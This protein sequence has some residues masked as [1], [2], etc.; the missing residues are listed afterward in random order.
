M[1]FYT[2]HSLSTLCSEGKLETIDR[3]VRPHISS[4]MADFSLHLIL[5]IDK[6]NILYEAKD[7]H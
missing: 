4:D 6:K 7:I 3:S 2:I 5:I 1:K